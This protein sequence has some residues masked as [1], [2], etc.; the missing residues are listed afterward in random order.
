[1]RFARDEKREILLLFRER[2][3]DTAE[4]AH[5]VS[6]L[7]LTLPW[8]SNSNGPKKHVL[9]GNPA[10]YPVVNII[11]G[12]WITDTYRLKRE[13]NSLSLLRPPAPA[14]KYFQ[15]ARYKGS[16]N[17]VRWPEKA[18]SIYTYFRIRVRGERGG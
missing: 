5:L 9:W 18:L 17:W 8:F 10:P 7:R 14:G 6:F 11:T 4:F 2:D 12:H 3:Y 13:P 15:R 16:R 1:R